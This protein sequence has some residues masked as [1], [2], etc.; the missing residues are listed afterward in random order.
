MKPGCCLIAELKNPIYT[1]TTVEIQ[2]IPEDVVR[3]KNSDREVNVVPY[4]ASHMVFL[5]LKRRTCR[6]VSTTMTNDH[7]GSVKHTLCN[8]CYTR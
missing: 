8:T 3:K 7:Y 2:V 6:T 5:Q 4:N 1:G